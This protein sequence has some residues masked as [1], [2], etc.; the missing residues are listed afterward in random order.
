VK[1]AAYWDGNLDFPINSQ[2][3]LAFYNGYN[4]TVTEVVYPDLASA[5]TAFNANLSP[6]K[7]VYTEGQMILSLSFGWQVSPSLVEE[8]NT[9]QNFDW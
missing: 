1:A 2:Y 9:V 7:F 3:T 5:T 8:S 4:T 6:Y